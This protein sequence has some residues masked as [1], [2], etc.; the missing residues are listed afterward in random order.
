MGNSN[1]HTNLRKSR[2]IKTSWICG[3]NSREF[4]SKV[5]RKVYHLEQQSIS[6][7]KGVF[8]IVMLLIFAVFLSSGC[9]STD[10]N[11]AN[12]NP[13]PTKTLIPLVDDHPGVEATNSPTPTPTVTKTSTPTSTITK[14]S[15]PTPT[16]TK[17]LTPTPTKTA[18]TIIYYVNKE[19]GIVHK[20]GCSYIK[21]PSNYYT[22][23]DPSGYQKCSRCWK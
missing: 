17:T 9:V 22:V 12:A 19:S 11:N 7:N 10:F 1:L 18:T 4:L 6:M 14:T 13:I 20:S 15:T 3:A 8:L 23:T 5:S 2:K 21:D 16:A